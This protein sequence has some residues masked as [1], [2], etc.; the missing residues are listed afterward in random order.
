MNDKQALE[1]LYKQKGCV[2]SPC[3]EKC[4]DYCEGCI[5]ENTGG[6]VTEAEAKAINALEYRAGK[7]PKHV[8]NDLVVCCECGE[9]LPIESDMTGIFCFNCGQ[10]LEWGDY[11]TIAFL[12]DEGESKVA[13]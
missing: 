8:Y 13:D 12:Y 4:I 7:P 1:I 11:E 10:R 2:N 9:T 3:P 5:Y 6:G